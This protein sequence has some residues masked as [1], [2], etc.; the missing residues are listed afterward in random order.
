MKRLYYILFAL[1]I[2]QYVYGQG[3]VVG[4]IVDAA[5][6]NPLAGAS[7]DLQNTT[8]GTISDF[9]GHFTLENIP[10]GKQTLVFSFIGYEPKKIEVN[11]QN[12]LVDID[13]IRLMPSQIGLSEVDVIASI[14]KDRE[15]PVA[16][17][18]LSH[19]YIVSHV[20]NTEFPE[21]LESTPSVYVTKQGG[22]YGDARI[23]VRGFDQRNTAVLINGI[24]VNDMEN[25]WVYWSNWAGLADVTRMIQV[26]RGLGASNLAIPSVGGTINIIT[27]TTDQKKGGVATVSI[28]NDGYKKVGL[29]LSTGRTAND[30]AFTFSGSRTTGNGYIEGTYID[31][32][33]YFASISKEINKNNQ[34]VFTAIGA[35]QRHGQRDFEHK[36][37]AQLD[38]YGPRYNDDF[39][40]KNGEPYNMEENF[41]HK[42]QFALNHYWNI[43]DD[44]FLATSAYW[45]MGR[46]GG[47]GDLGGIDG[48]RIFTLPTDSYGHIMFDEIVKWNTGR[49]NMVSDT[50]NNKMYYKTAEGKEGEAYI[51]TSSR[52]TGMIK[53]ASMNEHNW[54]GVLSTLKWD[55]NDNLKLTAGLDGRYYRGKHYRKLLDLLGNDYW[56]EQDNVNAREDWVDING[57]GVRQ[58]DELGRLLR[59]DGNDAQRLWG[60][61]D[62]SEHVAYDNDGIVDWI[63][64]FGQLEYSTDFGLTVFGSGSISNKGY[65]RVERFLELEGEQVSERYS[66]IGGTVKAGAN[67][68]INLHHN[69]FVNGG[70]Y[71]SQPI[72]DDVFPNFNNHDV[73][74]N[75]KNEKVI[76]VEFGYGYRS[77]RFSANLNLY[78]TQW[79]DKSFHINYVS[80]SGLERFANLT[81]LDALHQ[82]IELDFQ[83]EVVPNV[84][85]LNGFASI[86][87]WTWRNNVQTTIFDEA[88]NQ[89][90]DTINV[91]AAGLKVGDAAQ[92]TF[93]IGAT[94]HLGAGISIDGR[95]SYFANLYG[96]F[97]VEDRDSESLQGV[98]ALK[99]PNYGLTDVGFT[100]DFEIQD[101]RAMFRVN[102]NNLFNVKYIS[103]AQDIQGAGFPSYDARLKAARGWYGF[104]TTWNAS[105]KLYF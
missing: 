32:W 34:L 31:A 57:D 4:T 94:L 104:G 58:D 6:N 84:L 75:A 16:V 39:G 36:I 67:Y 8:T 44:A 91:Y 38:K 46:G 95:Y 92:T 105:L 49:V 102:V 66:F 45:S 15:T 9:E 7:I 10:N 20:G 81:G 76:A 61:P 2:T 33:S 47:T 74:V 54:Y 73:N 70:F 21:L 63:G 50:F 12:N 23:N 1:F 53:R 90:V 93:G 51:A 101:Y 80:E 79:N 98:Q 96:Q 40:Y 97:D 72:F 71:S 103:E 28:G 27:N 77:S 65:K 3:T 55:L 26:Q 48:G 29:T 52:E 17:S 37:G 99:L 19:D 30:W 14:A 18:K 25:G 24:P 68:N 43:S 89:P 56:F 11:V 83:A 60:S 86:N 5:E 41:Y 100:Y 78:R 82:G 59:P 22:G 42:P 35:P 13:T 64:V 85:S 87:D 69:I 62:A 88:N